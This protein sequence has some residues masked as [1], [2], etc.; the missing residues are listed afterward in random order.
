MSIFCF[1]FQQKPTNVHTH[2]TNEKYTEIVV[3]P[4]KL[5]MA[6][7][8]HDRWSSSVRLIE[9]ETKHH[10]EINQWR[11]GFVKMCLCVC[12]CMSVVCKRVEA[13]IEFHGIQK[14]M[15]ENYSKHIDRVCHIYAYAYEL[16]HN[17]TDSTDS[18]ILSKTRLFTVYVLINSNTILMESARYCWVSSKRAFSIVSTLTPYSG[19]LDTVHRGSDFLSLP[20]SLVHHV[21]LMW[22]II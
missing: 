19:G 20:L 18:D 21:H 10:F 6:S 4:R 1:L 7:T 15:S 3:V 8:G 12:V 22:T 13:T 9:S 17:T 14:K 2:S 11:T 16:P 5:N